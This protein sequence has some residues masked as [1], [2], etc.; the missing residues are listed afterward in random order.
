MTHTYK[1]SGMTCSGCQAKVHSLLS[2]VEGITN[3]SI[4]LQNATAD[5][6]MAKHISINTLKAALQDY[7]K[8]QITEEEIKPIS[9]KFAE[10]EEEKRTWL[11]T[12]KPILLI[13]AY[14]STISIIAAYSSAGFN[15]MQAMNVFMA[16][17]FLTFSFFKMLDLQGFA[18][19]YAMYDIVAKKWNSWGYIYAF[20]ELG[21]GIAYAIN[22][23]PL[24][25]NILTVVVM[26]ISIVGVLQSVLNKRTIKC[27]C[28][29]AVFNL[30][31]STVTIIEDG[32][33]IGMAA[34]MIII[35]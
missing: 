27:A 28:L 26:G 18:E 9:T 14:I 30:P 8:Y 21:L 33:M 29:G 7:P 11:A 16:G 22:F 32:L 4:N 2:K 34:T 12:Y 20:I 35:M 13:F 15:T 17:F 6:E 24:L 19:S 5:I 25:T 23:Q 3:L 10:T 1:V 31:M